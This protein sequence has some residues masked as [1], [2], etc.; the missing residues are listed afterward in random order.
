MSAVVQLTGET[1]RLHLAELAPFYKRLREVHPN[2][3]GRLVLAYL[4][5]DCRALERQ[6]VAHDRR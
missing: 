4:Q 1:R 5:D 2:L 3:P 6:E